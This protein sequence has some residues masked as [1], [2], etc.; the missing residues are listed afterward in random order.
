MPDKAGKQSGRTSARSAST[1]GTP[2]AP[3]DLPSRSDLTAIVAGVDGPINNTSDARLWLDKKGWVL[4]GEKYNSSKLSNILLTVSLL[5]KLPADAASAIRAVA[6]LIESNLEDDT[7]SSLAKATA[8]KFLSLIGSVPDAFNKAKDFLEATSTQQANTAV[9][10]NE[11]ATQ[12]ATT[13]SNLVEISSQLASAES[14]RDTPNAVQWPT[15]RDSLPS[16]PTLPPSSHD[17]SA[18]AHDVRLQQRLLLASRTVLIEVDLTNESTPK[19]RSPQAALKLHDALNKRLQEL[20]ETNLE[21]LASSTSEDKSKIRGIQTLE[22]GA[23]LVELNSPASA[24]RFRSYCMEFDILAEH[25]GV[26]A[27]I[28][29]KAFNLVLRFVPCSLFKPEDPDHILSL[30]TE[31]NL[32]PGS[33]VSASWLKRPNRRSPTQTVASVKVVCSSPEA[34]NHLLRERIYVAGHVVSVRKDLREPIRCNKCQEFGHIRNVCKTTERCAHCA[35]ESHT[36]ADCPPNRPPHCVSCGPDSNHASS[37]RTC[38]SFI[39]KS[40][41]LDARYP[42]NGMPYFPTGERWTWAPAPPKL[43]ISPPKPQPMREARPQDNGWHNV[44]PRHRQATLDSS[45]RPPR[46]RSR[47]PPPHSRHDHRRRSKSPFPSQ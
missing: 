46:S 20:D 31:N 9:V 29:S 17:P 6:Y 18:A 8:E 39:H 40:E 7:S 11:T 26:T 2:A 19:D 3:R 43:S 4:A 32:T 33:V 5:P 37:S 41:A 35:S 13:T 10:L 47:S 36:T 38:P 16:A 12:H 1:S 22:R 34:A 15:I 44:R 14:A 28:K 42:E 21:L 24:I 23:Y 45:L 27:C 30:E 25:L